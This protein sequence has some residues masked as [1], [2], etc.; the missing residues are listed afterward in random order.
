[1]VSPNLEHGSEHQTLAAHQ[2]LQLNGCS[3]SLLARRFFFFVEGNMAWVSSLVIVT[4]C[5]AGTPRRYDTV[6]GAYYPV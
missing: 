5:I 3:K 4:G 1:M 6:N 2:Y